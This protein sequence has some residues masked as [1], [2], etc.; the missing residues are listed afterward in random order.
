MR[1]KLVMLVLILAGI[2]SFYQ[3]INKDDAVVETDQNSAE[4][5]AEATEETS[6]KNNGGMSKE[7]LNALLKQLNAGQQK[8][9]KVYSD[10]EKEAVMRQ[11]A[12]RQ[13]SDDIGIEIQSLDQ[14]YK[15]CVEGRSL[16][17]LL[18]NSMVDQTPMRPALAAHC[19]QL[20]TQYPILDEDSRYGY[21][22]E[23]MASGEGQQLKDLL[24][25]YYR[26]RTDDSSIELTIKLIQMGLHQKNGQIFNMINEYSERS[27][28]M[29]TLEADLLGGE[30]YAYLSS[31][32]SAAL[33]KISCG[34]KNNNTC[35]QVGQFMHK[36]C[37]RDPSTCDIDFD[38]WYQEYLS[39]SIKTDVEFLINYYQNNI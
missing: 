12:N 25:Q 24:S 27:P 17:G 3:I 20:K 9:E 5:T 15:I 36:K 11:F 4:N 23:L 16:S 6:E 18:K 30:D 1:Y 28:H 31:V 35:S 32:R 13:Y 26:N 10:D 29:L 7:E 8:E 2:Y 21:K 22:A 14:E 37:Q 34:F 33:I 19:E 38:T 39:P